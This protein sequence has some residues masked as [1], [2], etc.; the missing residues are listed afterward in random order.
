MN[1]IKITTKVIIWNK[2]MQISLVF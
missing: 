1:I 2:I